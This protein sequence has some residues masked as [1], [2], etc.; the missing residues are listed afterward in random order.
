MVKLQQVRLGNFHG[1]EFCEQVHPMFCSFHGTETEET[2]A[3]PTDLI[4]IVRRIKGR[5]CMPFR[6][7]MTDEG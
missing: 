7:V 2:G 6:G 5:V 1:D 4:G 3:L